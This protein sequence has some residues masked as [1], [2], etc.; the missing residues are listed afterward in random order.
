[1]EGA[2]CFLTLNGKM[3]TDFSINTEYGYLIYL[4]RCAIHEEH[5]VGLPEGLSFEKV[6]QYAMD[7]DVA[8]LAFYAVE[9]LTEKPSR[10]LYDK[11][12]VRRDLALV[13]DINQ[14]FARQEIVAEFEARGIRYKEL[15]GTA[16]KKLYPQTEYRTM[17]DLDFVVEK[18]RLRE[19]GEVLSLLGYQC[20]VQGDYEI[21]GIRKP[22]IFVELHTDYFS[23]DT[24]FYGSMGEPLFPAEPTEQE[25]IDELY[26]YNVLHVAKH[27]YAGGCGIRRVLD[28]YYL[29]LYYGDRIQREYVDRYLVQAGVLSF[30][31]ELSQ[32]AWQ[33]FGD[34]AEQSCSGTMQ[35]YVLEA[36]LHGNRE[37]YVSS[38]MR[39]IQNDTSISVGTK[40]KYL[41]YRLFPGDRV[42]LKRYPV[43]KK[44]RILYP[45]CWIRR[46]I[47]MLRGKNRKV[48]VLD[49]KIVLQAEKDER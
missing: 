10:E 15:Q 23:S 48:S 26:L 46:I 2:S 47:C 33:W 17:S 19:A 22:D 28:M 3:Q 8:N 13:R 34:S 43:L 31:H 41:L 35:S 9:K 27:Y 24:D 18:V 42:M 29:D 20:S 7:H 16:L 30:S 6:Y 1:M 40:V 32:L 5:P 14:E 39:K 25:R 45:F 44:H 4:L 37:N 12:R 11:W 49:L 38:M 36:G 21:D